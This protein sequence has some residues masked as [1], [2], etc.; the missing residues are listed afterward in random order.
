ME[1]IGLNVKTFK[2]RGWFNIHA[3]ICM[4]ATIPYI[5][6]YYWYS[7]YL[8]F[9]DYMSLYSLHVFHS[10]LSVFPIAPFAASYAILQVSIAP[11]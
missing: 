1:A 11:S 7:A 9:S 2:E 10:Y 4:L 3:F 5:N 8:T 6:C